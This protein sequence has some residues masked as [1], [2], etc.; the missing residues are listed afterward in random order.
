MEVRVAKTA[1]FCF[2]VKRA[3]DKVYEL[4]EKASRPICTLGP[5]IHNETVVEDLKKKGVRT[6]SGCEEL[7][8]IQ[9]GIVVIRSH[10]V[11]RAVYEKIAER[12]LVTLLRS[13]GRLR[14]EVNPTQGKVDL[15]ESVL[16]IRLHKVLEDNS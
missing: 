8:D 4:A 16:M 9:E 2:G 12:G 10:G 5:V 14:V 7:D 13:P 11:G 6:L 3:V 1:G 15:E